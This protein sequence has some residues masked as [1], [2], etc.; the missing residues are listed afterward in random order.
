MCSKERSR[1]DHL[2]LPGRAPS[3]EEYFSTKHEKD[4][5]PRLT[6][7]VTEWLRNRKDAQEHAIAVESRGAGMLTITID[8]VEG[9][10]LIIR[11]LQDGD[12]ATLQRFGEKLGAAS[13]E[14]FAPYPWD[15]SN[16]L[17]SAFETAVK[18]SKDH[19]DASFIMMH[20]G[21][22][23]GHFFLWHAGGNEHS[24]AHGVDI[25]ELGVA[26]ADTYHGRGLGDLS[27]RLL[28]AMAAGLQ[29]DAVELTTAPTNDAGWKTYV[30]AGFEHVGMINNPLEVDVVAATAGVIQ[31]THYRMERQMVYV[32]NQAKRQQVF[33]YLSLKRDS[34]ERAG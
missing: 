18:K 26:V 20:N 9:H 1:G 11:T 6:S 16:A 31:A 32:I 33:D 22:P 12:E 8:D 2:S 28:N 17:S 13:K 29:K 30:R 5:K 4:W 24:R 34:A 25:P 21:E 23:V 15:K 14:L 3:L 19:I 7:V 27:V 10:P